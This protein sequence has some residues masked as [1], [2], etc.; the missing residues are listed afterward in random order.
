MTKQEREAKAALEEAALESG[1]KLPHKRVA[2][3]R[4]ALRAYTR[5]VRQAAE[6]KGYERGIADYQSDYWSGV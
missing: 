4:R 1:W 3:Y 6:G 2:D 5:A